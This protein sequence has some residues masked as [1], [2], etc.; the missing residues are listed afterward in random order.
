MELGIQPGI[1]PVSVSVRFK[2][3]RGAFKATCI[4]YVVVTA[5]ESAIL[6]VR[7]VTST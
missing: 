3:R 5:I 4:Q 2:W 1:V 7:E 6:Y